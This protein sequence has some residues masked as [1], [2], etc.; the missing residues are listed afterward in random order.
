MPRTTADELLE[1]L[2]PLTGWLL[3]SSFEGTTRCEATVHGIAHRYGHPVEAV[4]LADAAL[5]TV[6]GR[7]LTYSRE[8]TVPPLDHVSRVHALVAEIHRDGPAPREAA[9]RLD[10]ILA[11][12]P[13]GIRGSRSSPRSSCWSR[14]CSTSSPA[15]RSPPPP[16]SWRP[17]G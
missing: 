1:L 11:G 16:S 10:A 14:R 4:F 15:T 3:R 5:L 6:G 12:P 8:P 7:T 9:R 13:T 17:T 2:G